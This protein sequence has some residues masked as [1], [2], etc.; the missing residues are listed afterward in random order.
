[1][2][3]M[4]LQQGGQKPSIVGVQKHD[5]EADA[6]VLRNAMKGKGTDEKA[7]IGILTTRTNAQLQ[8]VRKAYSA[9]YE[10]KDL[11]KNIKDEVSGKFEKVCLALLLERP[12]YEAKCLEAAMKGM[13]TNEALLVEIICTRTAAH[14]DRIIKSYDKLFDKS[15]VEIVKSET[16]GDFEKLLVACLSLKRAAEG[17]VDA[18]EAAKDAQYLYDKGEKK[19]GTDEKAFI[20][21]LTTRSF[22]QI[23]L[24]AN[25]YE[26]ISKK[27]LIAAIESEMGGDLGNGLVSILK[28]SRDPAAYWA[29]QLKDTMKGMGT[30]DDKLIR[31]MVTRAEIDLKSVRDVFGDRYGKGKTL[32]DW[33]KSDCSGDYEDVLVA[34]CLG[35]DQK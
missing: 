2:A 4:P 13:G 11:L 5:P 1:M 16:K 17:K 35:N 20:D 10:Y 33:I 14:L 6:K 15:L 29:E 24:I 22:G 19:F 27:T 18:K 12:D 34:I 31:I 21:V 30:D 9:L 7:I 28:F 26:K 25:E 3:Q 32:L 23:G 8:A